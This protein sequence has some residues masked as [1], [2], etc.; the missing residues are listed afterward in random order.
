VIDDDLRVAAGAERER[1]GWLLWWPPW[2][3]ARKKN[4][5]VRDALQRFVVVCSRWCRRCCANGGRWWRCHG[6]ARWWSENKLP[7]WLT[8]AGKVC[9]ELRWWSEKVG[10]GEIGG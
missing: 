5:L 6:E 8:L 9:A 4:P 2:L 1:R 3:C 10:G 7:W